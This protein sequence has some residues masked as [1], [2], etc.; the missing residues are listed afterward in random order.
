MTIQ[1]YPKAQ[2]E[3]WIMQAAAEIT[4]ITILTIILIRHLFTP[5]SQEPV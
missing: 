5:V 2:H 4:Y 3:P 1:A